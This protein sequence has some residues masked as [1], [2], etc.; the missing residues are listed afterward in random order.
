M[1][2][3]FVSAS[4]PDELAQYFG[5]EFADDSLE[6]SYNVAPTTEVYAIR[7]AD[8]H[9]KLD[10][11]RWGLV[12]SW[13]KDIK[14]GSKLINA[15]AETLFDKPAF[16]AAARRRRCLIPADGFFEWAR[17]TG[18]K[19]KQPYY[20]QRGDGDPLAFAGIWETWTVPSPQADGGPDPDGEH[21]VITSCTIVT[22]PPNE[23]MARVHNRMP[24]LLAPSDWDRWI[25]PVNDPVRLAELLVPA[26]NGL[27][28]VHPVSTAVNRVGNNF[29]QLIEPDVN[30][31]E[32]DNTQSELFDT[33]NGAS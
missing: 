10:T 26:P 32:A 3:R 20:I 19:R 27:L 8:G 23:T 22:C 25:A 21:A 1:C 6:A 11:M 33:G 29:P 4:T 31:P 18:Q 30:P 7:D 5:A 9:R 28:V 16:R 24:V 14:I 17:V 2:G 15:R 13:A 12:P